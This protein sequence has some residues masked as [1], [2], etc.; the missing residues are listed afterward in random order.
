MVV[1]NEETAIKVLDAMAKEKAGRVTFMPL[2]KL[3]PKETEYPHSKDAIP[4]IK[5]LRFEDRHA[6]AFEQIFSKAIICPNLEV[7]SAYA[8]SNGLTA[9]TLD[10]DR[11]DR[12]GALTGGYLDARRSK[13]ET[14]KALKELRVQLEKEQADNRKLKDQM[15]KMNQE[16]TQLGNEINNVELQKQQLVSGRDLQHEITAKTKEEQNLQ[17]RLADQEKSLRDLESS[18]RAKQIQLEGLQAEL[19]SPMTATLTPAEV[20][21]LDT[22]RKNKTETEKAL[23]IATEKRS[24]LEVQKNILEMEINTKLRS[25][26]DQLTAELESLTVGE[27]MDGTSTGGVQDLNQKKAELEKVDREIKSKEDALTTLED[28]I[29][30][31]RGDLEERRQ[32]FETE[33]TAQADETRMAEKIKD[34]L[35]KNMQKKANLLQRKEEYTLK[36]RDLGVLPDDAYQKYARTQTSKVSPKEPPGL[37]GVPN[38]DLSFCSVARGKAFQ[39]S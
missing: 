39:D 29:E 9:V 7:A 2:N 20:K 3:R 10:G 37:F 6:K 28:E 32:A 5:K 1:D 31:I 15:E 23:V 18:I 16:I 38:A 19:A 26:R 34:D 21:Q 35:N 27:A 13:L 22:L 36:I 4:M 12:K 30:T 14:A 24:K 25:R 33:K 8:R 11:A 17:K